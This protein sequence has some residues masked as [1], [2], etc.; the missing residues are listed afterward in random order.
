MTILTASSSCHSIACPYM[1]LNLSSSSTLSLYDREMRHVGC[2]SLK[3]G[4]S[5]MYTLTTVHAC[6]LETV[7][8][9][10]KPGSRAVHPR[11]VNSLSRSGACGVSWLPPSSVLRAVYAV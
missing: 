1:F 2:R 11:L 5:P 3:W 6:S 9:I 7:T 10:T 4:K 8:F